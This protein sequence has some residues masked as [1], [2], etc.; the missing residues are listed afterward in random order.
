M[1]RHWILKEADRCDQGRCGARAFVRV[2][3]K[4]GELYFCGHHYAQ[5][6]DILIFYTERL[7][8]ERSR[9]NGKP[10]MSANV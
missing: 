2:T 5:H 1:V 9:I 8:D 6:E 10:S 4:T 7:V 3:L